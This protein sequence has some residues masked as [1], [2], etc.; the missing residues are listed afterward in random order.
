MVNSETPSKRN[1]YYDPPS[2]WRYGFPKPYRPLLNET[3]SE[4]LIRDG[5]PADLAKQVEDGELW[6]RYLG[7]TGE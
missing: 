6:C 3:I 1:L 4:T 2:G 5:Y 7:S